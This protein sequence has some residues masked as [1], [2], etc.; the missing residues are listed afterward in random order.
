[1]DSLVHRVQVALQTLK[2]H[3]ESE[4]MR[5]QDNEITGPQMYML[6]YIKKNENCKLTQLAELLDVKPSAITVMMDRLEKPGYVKRTNDPTDRRSILVELTPKGSEILEQNVA[7]RNEILSTYLARL[8]PDEVVTL[9]A[10]LEKL[11]GRNSNE[12]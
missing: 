12:I 9:T 8:T 3:V 6:F 10:L 7:R 4:M 5:R 11:T 1:M 2:R